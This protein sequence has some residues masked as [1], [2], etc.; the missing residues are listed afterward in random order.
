MSEWHLRKC[1]FSKPFREAKKGQKGVA[2]PIFCHYV[3]SHALFSFH[4]PYGRTSMQT[5]DVRPSN[6]RTY[7]QALYGR[8]CID[9][10]TYVQARNSRKRGWF[11]SLNSYLAV[12]ENRLFVHEGFFGFFFRLLRGYLEV[13]LQ[14]GIADFGAKWQTRI[15]IDM[16]PTSQNTNAYMLPLLPVSHASHIHRWNY[17]LVILQGITNFVGKS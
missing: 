4:F 6:L 2:H 3:L 7:V 12:S 8:T 10:W 14:I 9:L 5:Q 13:S 1:T 11:T 17:L 16:R 15:P